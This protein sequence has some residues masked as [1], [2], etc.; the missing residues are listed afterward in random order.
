MSPSSRAALTSTL[1]APA[2]SRCAARLSAT[3]S[4]ARADE[5]AAAI[6]HVDVVLF[7]VKAYDNA[8]AIPALAPLLGPS[9]TILTL[10]NDVDSAT[11]LA[12]AAGEDG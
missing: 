10:Q 6:G 4:C 9:S 7:R 8:T 3:S 2:V 11:E 5:D 1:S 12:A